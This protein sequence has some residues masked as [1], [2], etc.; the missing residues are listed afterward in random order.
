[1]ELR[2]KSSCLKEKGETMSATIDSITLI[3]ESLKAQVTNKY[4]LIILL[5]KQNQVFPYFLYGN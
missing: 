2:S 1:M 3:A 5:L 4:N